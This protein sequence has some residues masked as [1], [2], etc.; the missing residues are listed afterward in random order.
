M[1][2]KCIK[3][4]KSNDLS[5]SAYIFK[6][7]TTCA[8]KSLNMQML[9][10]STRKYNV[11]I[12]RIR[13]VKPFSGECRTV[14][15]PNHVPVLNPLYAG[16]TTVFEIWKRVF[17][18][19]FFF[20]TEHICTVCRDRNTIVVNDCGP[21]LTRSIRTI[22]STTYSVANAQ[23][24]WWSWTRD[25][26][27][28]VYECTYARSTGGS[29]GAKTFGYY[30]NACGRVRKRPS[31]VAF[32][33]VVVSFYARRQRGTVE[34]DRTASDIEKVLRPFSFGEW[35]KYLFFFF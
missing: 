8:I 9:V 30:Y 19:R 3:S 13:I 5:V 26:Y 11:E 32:V 17:K 34:A 4:I 24:V 15:H 29:L 31:E 21:K 1:F 10:F 35:Q 6:E 22:G 20:A 2:L 18:R 14:R 28:R 33:R 12:R 7:N 23:Q 27:T 25:A 16:K